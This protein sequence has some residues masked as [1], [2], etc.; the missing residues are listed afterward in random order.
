M[1]PM[2]VVLLLKS[3]AMDDVNAGIVRVEVSRYE[4]ICCRLGW[5]LR[6]NF[7]VVG[8]LLR[9]EQKCCPRLA[10]ILAA[11]LV[12]PKLFVVLVL[13]CAEVV[14]DLG[15]LEFLATL[16]ESSQIIPRPRWRTSAPPMRRWHGCF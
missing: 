4:Q 10:F 6:Q 1:Q 8:G 14:F 13:V 12:L 9:A 3:R 7:C 2:L 11:F 5:E 15:Q 16:I